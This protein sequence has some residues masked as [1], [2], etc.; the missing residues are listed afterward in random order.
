MSQNIDQRGGKP[1]R[2]FL[3]HPTNCSFYKELLR[4]SHQLLWRNVDGLSST[5]SAFLVK[6]PKE[7]SRHMQICDLTSKLGF[8]A[9]PKKLSSFLLTIFNKLLHKTTYKES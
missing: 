2:T 6:K 4:S 8:H 5:Q 7:I 1:S 3:C 9:S